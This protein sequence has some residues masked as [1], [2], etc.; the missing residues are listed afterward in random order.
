MPERGES[1]RVFTDE[2]PLVEGIFL[3]C[4]SFFPA[5]TIHPIQTEGISAV[6]ICRGRGVQ[7]KIESSCRRRLFF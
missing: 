2:F 4:I 6:G 7:G 3:V 5:N 1:L